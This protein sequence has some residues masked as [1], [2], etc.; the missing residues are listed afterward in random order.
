[1]LTTEI[2]VKLP[3]Y[4]ECPPK[5]RDAVVEIHEVLSRSLQVQR[6]GQVK[7]CLDN[8]MMVSTSEDVAKMKK[9]FW[10]EL[11]LYHVMTVDFEHRFGKTKELP[12]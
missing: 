5:V 11:K 4:D 2:E 9:Q 10:W 6:S 7:G 1:M 8:Q 3:D 12:V